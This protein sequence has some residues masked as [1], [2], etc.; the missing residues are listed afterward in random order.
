MRGTRNVG[1]V[2]AVVVALGSATTA[3]ASA[4]SFKA[5]KTGELK[6]TQL[7][8]QLFVTN[9][10]A[11]ECETLKGTGNVTSLISETQVATVEFGSC[12]AFSIP[13][14]MSPIE[15]EFNANGTVSILKEVT[16][17]ASSYCKV[18][19]PAQTDLSTVTYRNL[20][21]GKLEL[22]PSVRGITSTGSGPACNYGTESKGEYEG[23]AEVELVGG[24]TLEWS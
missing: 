9:G 11:I 3:A 24:G 12:N 16:I 10:G 22:E 1:V 15:F 5:S 6:A 20:A 13:T 8:S 2:L 23:M 18:T 4:H 7:S 21:G 17:K 14:T 19:I